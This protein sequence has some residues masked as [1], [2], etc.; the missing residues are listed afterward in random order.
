MFIKKRDYVLG[1]VAI[2]MMLIITACSGSDSTQKPN[3]DTA[4][5]EDNDDVAVEVMNE[6]DLKIEDVWLRSSQ[7]G[8]PT[9]L[10]MTFRNEGDE[11]DSLHFL[12]LGDID[13]QG[14]VYSYSLFY[15]Y[16]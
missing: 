11:D 15:S 7:E 16:G 6:S 2:A 10:Y 8:N 12:E 9:E 4:P 5:A 14:E 13:V 3:Q 1:L